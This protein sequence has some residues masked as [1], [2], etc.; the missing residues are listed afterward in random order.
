MV[1]IS[2]L[3]W[4]ERC[5][6]GGGSH[7]VS[8]VDKVPL[9]SPR[10]TPPRIVHVRHDE[11]VRRLDDQHVLGDQRYA[12]ELLLVHVGHLLETSAL[13]HRRS[14]FTEAVCTKRKIAFQANAA[15]DG[16]TNF[17]VLQG[18]SRRHP[19][20][21]AVLDEIASLFTPGCLWAPHW[22]VQSSVLHVHLLCSRLLLGTPLRRCCWTRSRDPAVLHTSGCRDAAG[23]SPLQSVFFVSS[24]STHACASTL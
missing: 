21:G 11:V 4:L 8:R 16:Q 23:R 3:S 5:C 2:C 1:S 24:Y 10:H 12:G 7:S 6:R 19:S 15:P 18:F 17:L 22:S 14:R 20:G 13:S 9:A